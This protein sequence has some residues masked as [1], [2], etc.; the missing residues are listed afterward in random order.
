MARETYRGE[1]ARTAVTI[2]LRPSD[3]DALRAHYIALSSEDRRLRFG[4]PIHDEGLA[5][6]VDR[7][8]FGRDGVFAVQ[9]DELRVIAAIHVA[10][11]DGPAELGLSVLPGARSQGLG[12]A[13]LKRSATW[14]RNRGELAVYVHCLSENAAMMHLARKNGMRI[15]HDGAESDGRLELAQPNAESLFSEWADDR[16]ATFVRAVRVQGR[17]AQALRAGA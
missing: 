4:A 6:Y 13:L 14:L 15:A 3:R 11:G 1:R 7:I 17:L 5:A 12:D 8:D 9:D 16:Y 2:R 10:V